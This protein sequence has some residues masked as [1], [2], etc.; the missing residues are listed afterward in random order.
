MFDAGS[1]RPEWCFVAEDVGGQT[2]GRE[3]RL[4]ELPVGV[5]Q[6]RRRGW[7]PFWSAGWI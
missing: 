4:I 2:V 7:A 3:H 5:A 6:P 1:M